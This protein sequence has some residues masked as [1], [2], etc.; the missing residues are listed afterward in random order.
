MLST[1]SYIHNCDVDILR[2]T[3]TISTVQCI[4]LEQSTQIIIL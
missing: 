1:T 4:W 3:P 2:L